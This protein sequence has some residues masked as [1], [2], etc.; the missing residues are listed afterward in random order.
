[1]KRIIIFSSLVFITTL[2]YSQVRLET[3]FTTEGIETVIKNTELLIEEP[4]ANKIINLKKPMQGNEIN[5]SIGI[6]TMLNS[7]GK[8]LNIPINYRYKHVDFSV[9]LPYYFNRKINY[10][11]E[12]AETKGFGDAVVGLGYKNG[13]SSF[14]YYFHLDVKLPTGDDGKMENG[15][16]VPLGT[17]STDFMFYTSVS[18]YFNDKIV[19][20][21]KFMYKLN[22]S[23]TKIAEIVRLD[24]PDGNTGIEDI[25]TIE[26]NIVNGNFLNID[27]SLAYLLKFGL[28]INADIAY[29]FIGEGNTNK[30]FSYSWTDDTKEITDISNKQDVKML[31]F[32]TNLVYSNTLF[33]ISAGI[34]I[35]LYTQRDEDNV[36]KD[37]SPGFYFK[38]DYNIFKK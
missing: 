14:V 20:S 36:E 11:I 3:G 6:E 12:T 18:K 16:L 22:G 28:S 37:R 2:L 35:P 10:S 26:Y 23:S 34:K 21:G 9:L 25:E 7:S 4:L 17:G 5:M 27:A 1:M 15:Y 31:D 29:R 32:R 19:L 8:L 38:I 13:S 24:N 30:K 33:D